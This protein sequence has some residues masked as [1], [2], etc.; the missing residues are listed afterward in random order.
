MNHYYIECN[1]WPWTTKSNNVFFI[2]GP[3][4][5]ILLCKDNLGPKVIV[6]YIVAAV[7]LSFYGFGAVS[8]PA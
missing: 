8:A 1:M 5:L 6:I 2:F 7:R 4:A 3:L